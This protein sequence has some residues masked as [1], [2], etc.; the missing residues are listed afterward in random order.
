LTARERNDVEQITKYQKMM[1]ELQKEISV[2]QSAINPNEQEWTF[3]EEED[4][5]RDKTFKGKLLV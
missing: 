4:K 1:L 5:R 3:E 2:L